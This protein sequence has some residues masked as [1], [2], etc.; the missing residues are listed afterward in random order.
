MLNHLK[1]FNRTLF[2]K[3]KIFTKQIFTQADNICSRPIITRP[4][5][6][7]RTFPYMY[8]LANYH[9]TNH[10]ANC[11][12]TNHLTNYHKTKNIRCGSCNGQNN[13]ISD[14]LMRKQTDPLNISK[15]FKSYD[16]Y[17]YLPLYNQY[18]NKSYKPFDVVF[19]MIGFNIID[20]NKLRQLFDILNNGFNQNM[21]SVV[22]DLSQKYPNIRSYYLEKKETTDNNPNKMIYCS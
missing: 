10:L 8:H 11:H 18:L 21:D 4:I 17:G 5:T 14:D 9:K 1:L 16:Q 6:C 15:I 12:K 20:I 2:I 22:E 13:L 3:E 19:H 7:L